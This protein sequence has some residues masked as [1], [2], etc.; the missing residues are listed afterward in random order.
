[1]KS[2]RVI[3]D[4]PELR[5]PAMR[6]SR[7]VYGREGDGRRVR[8]LLDS[9]GKGTRKEIP[10]NI[11]LIRWRQRVWKDYRFSGGRLGP[12]I[13]NGLAIAF[14]REPSPDW[15][16]WTVEE[17]QQRLDVSRTQMG[18]FK[19]SVPAANVIVGLIRICGVSR[20]KCIM[21]RHL[22]SDRGPAR[23]TPD[24]FL[25]ATDHTGKPTMGRF[26]EVKKPEEPA[27]DDQKAEIS[28]LNEIGLHA[29]IVRLIER[30]QW[31]GD[32]PPPSL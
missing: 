11:V 3:I 9:K 30:H 14:G 18:V 4:P 25:F 7:I 16:S 26:V 6:V 32:P 17:I 15:L 21:A 23:G 20:L 29:R 12:N 5:K 2:G 22:A 1:M 27:S 31:L 24:L 28:F 8:Y 10:E 19:S 13:W